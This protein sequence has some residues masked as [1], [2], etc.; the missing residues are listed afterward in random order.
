MKGRPDVANDAT[1]TVPIRPVRS[2]RA[3]FPAVDGLRGA[4][5]SSV[6][7]Y[8]TNMFSNGLFGVDI[9]FV[10]SGFFI[11]LPLMREMDNAG[12]IDLSGFYRRRF[13]RLIPG[14]VISLGLVVVL[15]YLFGTL[16]EAR[17][18]STQAVAALFQGSQLGTVGWIRR[19]LGSLRSHQPAGSHV[20]AEHHRAV[21]PGLAAVHGADVLDFPA[22]DAH[23]HGRGLCGLRCVRRDRAAD[24]QREQQ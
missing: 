13:K 20:V 24:V 7:L 5:I 9:F 17:T 22:L 16:Q 10:L 12:R 1:A 8:H 4:A 6:L 18:I 14:L 21:L 3:H 11:T 19:L 23:R 2:H 15:A